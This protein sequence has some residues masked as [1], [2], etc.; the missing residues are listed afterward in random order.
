MTHL[1]IIRV[2]RDQHTLAWG[3]VTLLTSINGAR[4]IPHV[5]HVSGSSHLV[6][7][8]RGLTVSCDRNNQTCPASCYQAQQTGRRAL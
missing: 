3:A 7:D 8:T 2:A 4:I 1:C 5:V 6:R